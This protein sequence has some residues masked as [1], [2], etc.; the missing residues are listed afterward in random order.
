[1]LHFIYRFSHLILN[2]LIAATLLSITVILAGYFYF[3]P[4]LPSIDLVDENVLQV[5]MKIFSDD[6]KLIGE[7]GEQKR[8]TLHL[9]RYLKMLN[10]LFWLRRMI[11]S[12]RIQ[13]LGCFHSQ[14]L[15]YRLFDIAKL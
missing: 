5:P 6:E 8:R 7:F 4:S 11:S 2:L 14:G 13:G 9:M 1:M 10:M 12:F 15:Y 3:K